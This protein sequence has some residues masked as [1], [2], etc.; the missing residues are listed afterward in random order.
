MLLCM[1][2]IFWRYRGNEPSVQGGKLGGNFGPWKYF[3]ARPC[4][5][6]LPAPILPPPPPTSPPVLSSKKPTPPLP[7]SPPPF[8]E[9]PAIEKIQSRSKISISLEIFNL[10]WNFQSRTF[11]IPHKKR[12]WRVARLKISIPLEIF[13]P[14]GRSWIF[15]IF[16]PLGFPLPSNNKKKHPRCPPR[17][18]LMRAGKHVRFGAIWAAKIE[19]QGFVGVG[20]R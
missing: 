3:S 12:V 7:Q 20:M 18:F 16:G 4:P 14:G 13:T 19:W 1:S 8:P 10:A 11:R 6:T 2:S 15:S 9:G 5:D 17:K